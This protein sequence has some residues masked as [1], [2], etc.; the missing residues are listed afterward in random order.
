M[1]KMFFAA[2]SVCA[3]ITLSAAE[4]A[5]NFKDSLAK[6]KSDGSAKGW[7]RNGS[8]RKNI[9]S[10][11]VTVENG[12]ACFKI[13]TTRIATEFYNA[14]YIPAKAGQTI[15]LEI[16]AGGTGTLLASCYSY[17]AKK[18]FFYPGNLLKRMPLVKDQK[19]YKTSIKLADGRKGEK[20]GFVLLVIGADA[21]SNISIYDIK[22]RIA[23]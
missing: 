8:S 1:K 22:A 15:E 7:Y 2:L 23:E 10:G 3:A 11:K 5:V 6:A 21:K 4:I 14:S 17:N 9:G 18:V 16:T 20:L 19:V 13:E 12:V